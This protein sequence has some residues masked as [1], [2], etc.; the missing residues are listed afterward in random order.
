MEGFTTGQNCKRK[1]ELNEKHLDIHLKSINGV[2]HLFIYFKQFQ[3]GVT[4]CADQKIG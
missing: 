4:V 1:D 3:A 2:L